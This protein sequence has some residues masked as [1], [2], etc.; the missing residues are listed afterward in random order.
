MYPCCVCCAESVKMVLN[1]G[2][3]PISHRFLFD[4][5]TDEL[6]CPFKIGFCELCGL[7]QM[8]HPPT[9]DAL[10]P[11]YHWIQ[12]NEPEGHLDDLVE[13]MIQLPGINQDSNF[14]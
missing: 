2:E 4:T 14:L 7:V 11:S 10:K 12:Y 5:S 8:I 13:S 1:F 3:Q 9:S 6:S